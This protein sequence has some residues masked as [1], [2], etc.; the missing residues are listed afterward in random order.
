MIISLRYNKINY[1]NSLMN[2]S[3]ANGDV[4]EYR[5]YD[6]WGRPRNPNDFTYDANITYGGSHAY[7]LRG[8]CMHE[9]LEA[10]S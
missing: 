9:H 1:Q 8:Y 4:V 10:F 7:T 6:A 2:I 5:S 3:D